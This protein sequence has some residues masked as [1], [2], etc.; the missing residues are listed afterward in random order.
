MSYDTYVEG[1]EFTTDSLRPHLV[2]M[3]Q[4]TRLLIPF[5]FRLRMNGNI[6]IGGRP[7]GN[8]AEVEMRLDAGV[9]MRLDALLRE[10]GYIT[11]VDHPELVGFGHVA[12]VPCVV[13]DGVVRFSNGEQMSWTRVST[14]R[15]VAGT[16]KVLGPETPPRPQSL[17]LREGIYQCTTEGH[18]HLWIVCPSAGWYGRG[19]HHLVEM[20]TDR[21]A[22][23]RRDT[24][25]ADCVIDNGIDDVITPLVPW[26]FLTEDNAGT[27]HEIRIR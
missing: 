12:H 25:D 4:G 24:I 1:Y 21:R 23:R 8:F 2:D 7:S 19:N 5:P 9:E 17:T 26:G 11:P 27:E 16:I 13:S 3:P 14:A 20:M 18:D 6:T 15:H 22:G 10:G